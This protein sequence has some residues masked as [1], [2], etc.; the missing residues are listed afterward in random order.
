MQCIKCKYLDLRKDK[1]MSKHGFG[2]CLMTMATFYSLKKE[3]ECQHFIKADD[4][5]IQKRIDWYERR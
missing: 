1:T 4:A 5:K 2:F 3:H